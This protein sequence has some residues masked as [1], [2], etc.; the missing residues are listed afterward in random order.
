MSLLLL[1]QVEEVDMDVERLVVD[2][3]E[4]WGGFT[5]GKV[6]TPVKSIE[7]FHE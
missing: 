2:M 1:Q 5:W 7:L 4:D 3:E 6:W